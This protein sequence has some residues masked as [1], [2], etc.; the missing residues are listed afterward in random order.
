LQGFDLEYKNNLWQ[1]IEREILPF[2]TK[3]ARY[4]GNELNIIRKPHDK[5]SLK[6]A[7][8]F[9]E[10]YEI[11]MSYQGMRIL[12][13]IINK[14]DDVLAERAF[15]VW[16]DMEEKLRE[17]KTPLFSLES[18]TPLKEFDVLGFHLTYEMTYVSAIAMLDLAGIPIYSEKRGEDDPVIMAGG[19][20]VMNPEPMADF[21]DA[22]FIGEAEES[23]GQIIEI[24]KKA[25]LEN[26]VREK[27]LLK[28]S[29]VPGVYV[30][31][32][33]KAE[34]DGRRFA[35]L[36]KLNSEVPDKIKY[37]TARELKPE[38]YPE[39]PLIPNIEIAHDHLSV[40]IMRGCI[41]GCRFCQ[42][43][44]QYRPQRHRPPQEISEQVQ[45]TLAE[46]GYE[47]VTLLSL[48]ST[49][50]KHLDELLAL[51]GPPLT[52]K[53][54]S[55]GLP[56]LRPETITSTLLST[57][58]IVRKSGLTIAPEAGTERMRKSLG[59]NISDD[60]IFAAVEKAV[61]EGYK[62][63]KLYFMIGMPGETTDDIDGITATLRKIWFITKR[64]RCD[65]NVTISP[66]NPKSHTPW[67]WAE[68]NDLEKLQHKIVRIL[69][70]TR[71]PSIKIK[72]PDLN[73]CVLEGVLGRG[74][75]R[76][77]KVIHNAY[78]NGARLDGWSE[79]FDPIHWNSAFEQT[80]IDMREYSGPYDESAPL[81]W[82]H[83]DKGI[84]KE[85]LVKENQ[86]SQEAIPP[87][88]KFD[89]KKKEMDAIKAAPKPDGFG[90]RTRRAP[91]K[92]NTIPGTYKLRLRYTRGR[93]LRFLSHL[94]NIRAFYRA[95]RRSGI[96]VAFS[97]GFHPHI[98]AS[99]GPPLPVGYVSEAEY[100]DLQLTQPFREDFVRD[101]NA[102]LPSAMQV[103]GHKQYFAKVSSLTKQLNLAEYEL[104][105]AG[106]IEVDQTRIEQVLSS[107]TL[108]VTRIKEDRVVELDARR[109]LDNL[110]LSGDILTMTINQTPEGQIKPE[111]IMVFGLGIDQDKA[112][113]LVFTRKRQLHRMGERTIEPLDLV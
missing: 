26:Y 42:A 66:F 85:F 99:F 16:P 76:L 104:E 68:Q 44:Y 87:R 69:G 53:N 72:Y 109:F 45:N 102:T 34:Y 21:I 74:D 36:T 96:P 10:M 67:Q 86:R 19:P 40:E 22:F 54:I 18:A 92:S 33:Y 113:T 51:I 3:P 95:I 77:S 23:I 50:Y 83:I 56:S 55:L 65:V 47:D 62:S 60:E 13:N 105:L 29:G 63:I 1:K 37:V 28:L 101:M 6:I 89:N 84:K 88:T 15:A 48:S 100:I 111:E 17:T 4:I 35:G 5:I 30:P 108:A 75:R 91:A 46:T 112:K 25:K 70:D 81:P 107:N 11:G 58:G 12:Y 49:D 32:F 41:R 31:R 64:G 9:P 14:Q 39:R 106:E 8:C 7:L 38:Y 59:K 57:L 24:L 79:W 80:G 2:V 27:T 52:A 78:K 61:D 110:T 97:E 82:D 73:L 94:D 43:G 93:D 90:R 71:K 20:S 103:T 98:K